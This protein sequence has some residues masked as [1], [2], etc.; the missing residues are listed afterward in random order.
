MVSNKGTINDA[1]PRWHKNSYVRTNTGFK[2][3]WQLCATFFKIIKTFQGYG[4]GF[5]F[6]NKLLQ[7]AVPNDKNA[8]TL[9][10]I[11]A[12]L[13]RPYLALCR[14]PAQLHSVTSQLCGEVLLLK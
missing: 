5:V 1:A 2:A 7:L 8:P 13:P 14:L 12:S 9:T 11:Q 4:F 3:Y 10:L 6:K